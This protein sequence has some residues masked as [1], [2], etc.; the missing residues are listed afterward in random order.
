MIGLTIVSNIGEY[1]SQFFVMNDARLLHSKVNSEFCGIDNSFFV[2]PRNVNGHLI[3]IRR[4]KLLERVITWIGLYKSASDRFNVLRA[5]SGSFYYGAGGWFENS[6]VGGKQIVN[7]LTD[8]VDGIS[9][10]LATTVNPRD[11]ELHS[12]AKEIMLNHNQKLYDQLCDSER[13]LDNG[14]G[15]GYDDNLERCFVDLSPDNVFLGTIGSV[16]DNIQKFEGF[17]SCKMALITNDQIIAQ[18][19]RA[20]KNCICLEAAEYRNEI[21]K[22]A[23]EY[24]ARKSAH[25]GLINDRGGYIYDDNWLKRGPVQNRVS[26]KSGSELGVNDDLYDIFEENKNIRITKIQHD[27]NHILKKLL[28]QRYLGILIV[29]EFV[30]LAIIAIG[31]LVILKRPAFDIVVNNSD[32]QK[33][34]PLERRRELPVEKSVVESDEM[35]P[36]KTDDTN[37][38]YNKSVK[39]LAKLPGPLNVNHLIKDIHE[40]MKRIDSDLKKNIG[41]YSRVDEGKI[42]DWDR[43]IVNLQERMEQE[44][45]KN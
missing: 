38:D 8:V 13:P 35:P 29:I 10:S 14:T 20:R 19:I 36:N 33:E 34:A 6:V 22:Y 25:V 7:L 44:R 5:Q 17:E 45:T 37:N 16:I 32:I 11:W 27:M 21:M 23:R 3:V 15:L 24:K 4:F 2:L 26:E 43:E 18:H 31:M 42:E 12:A 30:F 28:T 1:K 9:D 41:I 39:N 40:R